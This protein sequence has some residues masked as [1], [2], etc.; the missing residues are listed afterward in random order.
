MQDVIGIGGM[1][2]VYRARDELLERDVAVKVFRASARDQA[3][4]DRQENEIKLLSRLSHH[5]LVNINDAI[6]ILLKVAGVIR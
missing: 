1:A 2:A 3:D 6:L 5:S 4:I